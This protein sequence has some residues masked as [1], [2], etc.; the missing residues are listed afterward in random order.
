MVE[1][2]CRRMHDRTYTCIEGDDVYGDDPTVNKLEALAS[3]F[4]GKEASMYV[5]SGTMSNLIACMVH[6][7]ERGRYAVRQGY[8]RPDG[9]DLGFLSTSG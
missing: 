3:D 4:L 6:C 7:K 1:R 5:P 9:L 2:C 8:L